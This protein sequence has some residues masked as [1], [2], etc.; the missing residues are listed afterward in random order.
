MEE[1][2]TQIIKTEPGEEK[3]IVAAGAPA[4]PPPAQP[5]SLLG[6]RKISPEEKLQIVSQIHILLLAVIS[7]FDNRHST[8]AAA[9]ADDNECNGEIIKK[10]GELFG[11]AFR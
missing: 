9:T 5:E 11:K 4:P 3:E 7:L 10:T 8:S 2:L 1:P 6:K